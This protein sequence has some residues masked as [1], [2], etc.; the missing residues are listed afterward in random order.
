MSINEGKNIQNGL[1]EE[2]KGIINQQMRAENDKVKEAKE[3]VYDMMD[4]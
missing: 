3:T 2:Q 1:S 4:D